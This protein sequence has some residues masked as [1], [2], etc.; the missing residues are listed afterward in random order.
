VLKEVFTQISQPGE[1]SIN[2]SPYQK[3][4]ALPVGADVNDVIQKEALYTTLGLCCQQVMHEI[5]FTEWVRQVALPEVQK[6]DEMYV[7]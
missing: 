6:N 7:S 1:S 5:P 3:L 4:I 2:S